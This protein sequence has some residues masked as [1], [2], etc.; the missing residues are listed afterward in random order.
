MS[1]R[2]RRGSFAGLPLIASKRPM[3]LP[4]AVVVSTLLLTLTSAPALSQGRAGPVERVVHEMR[5]DTGTDDPEPFWAEQCGGLR[6]REVGDVTIV[7][8]VFGDGTLMSKIDE[9]YRWYDLDTGELILTEKDREVLIERPVSETVDEQAGTRTVVLKVDYAGVPL[10]MLRP[11]GGVALMSG[12]LL[13]RTATVVFDLQTGAVLDESVEVT[14]V[15]GPHPYLEPS[16]SL[17]FD[18]LVEFMCEQ[19]SG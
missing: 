18:G 6:I 17:D 19:L 2:P 13:R 9:Q 1:A 15:A 16:G 4:I 12:G 8:T 3:A 11:H 10:R 14:R 7:E 5:Y